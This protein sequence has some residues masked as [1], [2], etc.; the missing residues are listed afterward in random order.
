MQLRH[1]DDTKKAARCCDGFSPLLIVLKVAYDINAT[2]LQDCEETQSNCLGRYACL[3][4]TLKPLVGK[5]PSVWDAV[6]KVR[7]KTD[8]MNFLKILL[9]T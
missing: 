2:S 7:K 4:A 1:K 3:F 6:D 5:S 9:F 8:I